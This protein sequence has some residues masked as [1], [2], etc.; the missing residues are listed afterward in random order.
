MDHDFSADRPISS[1]EYDLLGRAP[2]A[3]SLAKAIS[4]WV[5]KDSLVVALHGA[6]GSGK[7]SIK[8]MLLSSYSNSRSD[9]P[10][11]LAI[12]FN[13]WEWAGQERI[14][15]SFFE[16][17]AASV[18]KKD[19]SEK[20]TRIA[21]K[22]RL[23]GQYLNAGATLVTG[24]SAALPTLFSL[25]VVF[26]LVSTFS[27]VEWLRN[28][29]GYGTGVLA[30]WAAF[31]LWGRGLAANLLGIAEEYAK[32]S[33]QSLE[34]IKG[35]LI[36]SL[37]EVDRPLLIILDDID[38]LTPKETR[39]VFQLVKAN[40]DFP[41]VIYLL[42][43]QRDIV[44]KRLS[45]RTQDGRAYLEK[46]IQV[47]FDIPSIEQAKL[48]QALF[49]ALN[50][51]LHTDSKTQKRFDRD[52]WSELFYGGVKPYFSNLRNIYRF[53]S[54]LSFY[55]SLL[56]G[57]KAF[58][59]NPVDLIGIE[60]LRVFEPEVYEDLATCKSL[61]TAS[62]GDALEDQQAKVDIDRI[63]S[64]ATEEKREH[65][66][67]I[68]KQLFPTVESLM[69]GPRY[70]GE[71]H[72]AW[73]KE[74]R[75]CHADVFSRYFQLAIPTGEISQSELDGLI[76]LSSNREGLVDALISLKD[77]GR[78][79][80][81][82]SQ[83]DAYK[84]DITLE[85]SDTFV[86]ALMDIG[87][88]EVDSSTGFFG[89]G[90]HTNLVRIVLWYLRQDESTQGRSDKLLA[91][92]SKT[93]GLSIMASILIGEIN[94][95]G[96]TSKEALLLTDDAALETAKKALVDK[97]VLAAANNSIQF[98]HNAHLYRLLYIWREWGNPE[99][100]YA[101]VR[102]NVASTD[103]LLSFL[104]SFVSEVTSHGFGNHTVRTMYRLNLESIETYIPLDTIRT[105]RSSISKDAL[106][107]RQSQI[108]EAL[109]IA[110]AR[111]DK[112]DPNERWDD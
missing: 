34:E 62:H 97:I 67:E 84:Q 65:V 32:G 16:Q 25:A 23:Y 57:D 70:G 103:D 91:A 82:L 66:R 22:I 6:W 18:G 88:L 49:A 3:E 77:Q 1:S 83:L 48:E 78:L 100:V 53:S 45:S 9:A 86:T 17:I 56:Q 81:A 96:D 26:G 2:F 52:R 55:V 60:C 27:S 75:V 50:R 11:P 110:I 108:I 39:L 21:T 92:F 35:E 109:D 5:G 36:R 63:L 74:L 13:P 104:D 14:S 85:H 111:K 10:K 93:D 79:E 41:N 106:T 28:L 87:D 98:L 20:W 73:F 95:R 37:K 105:M 102:D 29:S 90:A 44:E 64:K 30:L 12:E 31:L 42:L 43:F 19:K 47:P 69:G 72:E 7:T 107:E 112:G 58:E 33:S 59:V 24:V 68:I 51:I 89:I 8:N 15:K 38:R 99:D 54:T 76:E 101:W 80:G 46:I 71:F 40:A 61:M 94:R 4:S